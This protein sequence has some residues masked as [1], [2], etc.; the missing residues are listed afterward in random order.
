MKKPIELI[1]TP[2]ELEPLARQ[3]LERTV[4]VVFD[5]LRATST[6]VTALHHGAREII[7]VGEIQEALALQAGHPDWLLAGERGGRRILATR[8]GSVDFDLGNSP[9]EFTPGTVLNRTLVMT[10]TNGTR[11]LQACRRAGMLLAASFLNLKAT[12]QVL[13]ETAA[14]RVILVCAGTGD[15]AADE[16]TLGA[17][18]LIDLLEPMGMHASTDAGLQARTLYAAAAKDLAAAFAQ[19]INGRRLAADPELR[20][21][22]AFCAQRDVVPHAVQVINNAARLHRAH[23]T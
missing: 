13:S 23:D 4:C 1:L 22:I 3:S 7:V 6:M 14:E 15:Q 12:A 18:A 5:V 16:D 17:G 9:R 2:S 20:P 11:A 8:T 21:D 19:S 10:T